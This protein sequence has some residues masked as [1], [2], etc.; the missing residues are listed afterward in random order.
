MVTYE[1]IKNRVAGYSNELLKDIFVEVEVQLRDAKKSGDKEQ[2][3]ILMM[4]R[5]MVWDLLESREP[6]FIDKYMEGRVA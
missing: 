6:A 4:Y 5:V 1:D 3:K 2:A